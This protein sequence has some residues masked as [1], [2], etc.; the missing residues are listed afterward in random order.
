LTGYKQEYNRFS[1]A[2]SLVL[3]FGP[4]LL[5]LTSSLKYHSKLDSQ[6]TSYTDSDS[7]HISFLKT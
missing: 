6:E 2:D 3:R 7:H 4:A 5:P 1:A